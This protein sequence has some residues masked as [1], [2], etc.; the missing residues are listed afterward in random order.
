MDSKI[1]T[2]G[3]N[4]LHAEKNSSHYVHKEAVIFFKAISRYLGMDH[5]KSW[6]ERLHTEEFFD[7][8]SSTTFLKMEFCVRFSSFKR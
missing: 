7:N 8:I 4:S 5:Q 2:E 6:W 1:Y 3:H